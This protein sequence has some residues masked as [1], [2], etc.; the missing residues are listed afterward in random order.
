APPVTEVVMALL[1]RPR[2]VADL[3]L[4]QS[5]GVKFFYRLQ[6]CGGDEVVIGKCRAPVRDLHGERRLLFEIEH[7]ERE[8]TGAE[9]D[10]D[11]ERFGERAG[12]LLRQSKDEIEIRANA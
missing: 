5:R 7:V 6:I 8:M 11:V 12:R 4:P 1:A 2:E 3:V 10:G 9:V